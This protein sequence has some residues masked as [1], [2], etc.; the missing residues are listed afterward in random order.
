MRLLLALP[1]LFGFASCRKAPDPDPAP[2]A[3]HPEAPGTTLQTNHDSAEIFRRAFWR[4]PTPE[5]KILNAERREWL[6]ETDGV[7]RWQ[8]FIEIEPSPAFRQWFFDE[9]PFRLASVHSPPPLAEAASAPAWFP[10]H[11][12]AAATVHQ[13]TEGTFV[14]IYNPQDNN[15]Y[16]TDNG[17]GFLSSVS[18]AY[19]GLCPDGRKR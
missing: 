5:D 18:T 14:V 11:P 8:W 15:L 9:N 13:N 10:R 19:R 17:H 12:P 16:A 4:D 7:R 1:L 2:P 3:E 6:S